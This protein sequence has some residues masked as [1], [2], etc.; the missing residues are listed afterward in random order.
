MMELACARCHG[1]FSLGPRFGCPT[2][3]ERGRDEPLEL[4]FEPG[5]RGGDLAEALTSPPARRGPDDP[6]IWR[7]R[8][9]LPRLGAELTLGEGG[10]PLLASRRAGGKLGLDALLLKYEGANPTGSFKDRFQAVSMSAA[11]G[12]GF[13]RA[14]CVSTGNHGLAAAAYARLAGLACLVLLHEE[15]PAAFEEA[16]SGCGATVARVP[17]AERAGLMRD[18]VAAGWFPATCLQPWP[19]PNPFGAEGYKTIA[20]ELFEQLGGPPDA[21]VVPVGA[22]DGLYGVAKGFLELVELGLITRPTPVFAVQPRGADALVLAAEAGADEVAPLA[23]V[24]PSPALSIREAETGEHALRLLRQTGGGALAVSDAEILRAAARLA[25]EPLIVDVASA[26]SV[27]GAAELA[28]R[29]LISRQARVVALL[30]A[31][32]ARWPRPP[33]YATSGRVL[34]GT[35]ADVRRLVD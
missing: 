6:G 31:S 10:T 17:S 32:G 9:R 5:H 16:I 12:L 33:G 3:H 8:A 34:R 26:A 27:A 15:S 2:C 11:L 19:V 13:E 1:R 29:G 14:F 22:G 20:Y 30:T 18:L 35:A 4:R 24:A 23:E 28:G 25:D 7:W 21:V